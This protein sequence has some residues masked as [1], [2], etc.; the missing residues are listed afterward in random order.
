MKKLK[1][2]NNVRNHVC[3]F[4]LFFCLFIV[5]FLNNSQRNMLCN[6]PLML[7]CSKN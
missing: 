6:T 5:I 2:K 3:L 4:I 7:Q 1:R